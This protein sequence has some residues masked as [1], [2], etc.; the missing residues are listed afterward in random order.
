MFY[1]DLKDQKQPNYLRATVE[2]PETVQLFTITCC[3]S[4]GVAF[5]RQGLPRG[6]IYHSMCTVDE[7]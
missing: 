4:Y 2:R 1:H 6:F 3:C 7:Y 5:D